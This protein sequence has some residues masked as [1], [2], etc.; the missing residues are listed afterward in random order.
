M[1]LMI[2]VFLIEQ[3]F[4][5]LVFLILVINR[6]FLI[7]LYFIELTAFDGRY[8]LQLQ[9]FCLR[10]SVFGFGLLIYKL[11]FLFFTVSLSFRAL[12]FIFIDLTK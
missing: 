6:N 7:L 11:F 4:K 10:H 1:P 2:H 9:I 8:E 12:K 5:M 3:A